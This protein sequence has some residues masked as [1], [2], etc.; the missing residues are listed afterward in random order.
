MEL[1]EELEPLAA[2][3]SKSGCRSHW[4][5][6][7]VEELIAVPTPSRSRN[8]RQ[9]SISASNAFMDNCAFQMK[10]PQALCEAGENHAKSQVSS[11]GA[12]FCD[13]ENLPPGPNLRPRAVSYSKSEWCKLESDTDSRRAPE[14]TV[15]A[16]D[17][18]R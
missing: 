2:L 10:W 9:G 18:A 3:H 4:S 11:A 12:H 17:L 7:L 16:K 8:D 14:F 1:R 15:A 5:D 13:Q 6:H